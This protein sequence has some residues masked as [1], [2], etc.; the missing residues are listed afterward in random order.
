MRP[1]P[2][3]IPADNHDKKN[4]KM[5]MQGT[6]S[7]SPQPSKT[8]VNQRKESRERKM[9]LLQD[10]DKLKRKLRLEENV[11]RALE[12]AF[13]RPLGV[14]PR[15]PPY[16]PP[17]TL[18]LLAEVAVL[19]E[20]VVRLEEQVIV[21]RQEVARRNVETSSSSN[22]SN[23]N[24]SISNAKSDITQSCSMVQ[25]ALA[26]ATSIK[27]LMDSDKLAN[28]KQDSK[29][30]KFSSA[31]ATDKFGKE[32][33]SVMAL[34]DKWSPN[35]KQ[36]RTPTK[37][38][39]L[40][41]K[42]SSHFTRQVDRGLELAKQSSS[43]YFENMA[44]R[45]SEEVLS[46][47]SAIFI[48]LN[49]PTQRASA[50]VSTESFKRHVGPYAHLCVI[51]G[52]SF[53]VSRS[54][55]AKF[56]MQ[57]LKILLAKLKLVNIQGLTH[58]QKLAFWINVYNS[59]IMIA[60]LEHGVPESSDMVA[61]LMQKATITVGGHLL[62]AITIE[63]FILRLPYHLKY[64]CPKVARS[65]E[66][67]QYGEYALEWSEP[68]VTFALSCGSRS[69]PAVRVYTE[70]GVETELE[71]AKRDYM[72]ASVGIS[73]TKKLVIPKILTWYLLDFGKDLESL[74]DW[75]CLQLP[76]E[77]RKAAVECLK[78]RKQEPISDY[79][80]ITTYD[81]SFCFLLHR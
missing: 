20:E 73:G 1:H 43:T 37:Q 65:E 17:Q 25:P 71:L 52:D 4:K 55:N 60:I 44:N 70:A 61:E 66:M 78:S 39:P 18:D 19:E 80:H 22:S 68:L 11:H 38:P 51:D 34:K 32:N 41:E 5:E 81:F 42:D 49:T 35:A 23:D 33:Q 48:R 67:K 57:R 26:R 6:G 46:C 3:P 54:A 64:T 13:T 72:Q 76:D 47:L 53:D 21:F 62:N 75:I 8:A 74:V 9:T 40:T 50:D 79:V 2:P 56:L 10:V 29:K 45:T 30:P 69:S 59:C 27:K 15:L 31:I 16:L 77:M 24:S 12:R 14:L 58:Q 63:H 7:G 28:V 36:L